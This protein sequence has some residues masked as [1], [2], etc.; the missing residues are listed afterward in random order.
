M[1]MK[2]IKS[3]VYTIIFFAGYAAILEIPIGSITIAIPCVLETTEIAWFEISLAT[4]LDII[5]TPPFAMIMFYFIYKSLISQP[6]PNEA[7]PSEIK[8]NT[9]KMLLYGACITFI[10]GVIMHAV[11]NGLNGIAGNIVPPPDELQIAIYYFDEVL[12]HKL[13][14][15]GIIAFLIG[16]MVIQFW[17]RTNLQLSKVDLFGVYFWP[18]A[19]G[20]GYMLTLVEG[21]AA[22]DVLVISLILIAVILYYI[23]FRG[24]KLE[25][26]IFTHF[27][28]VLL[29]AIVVSTIVF[30]LITGFK[31]G[32]PFF[33][34]L[35]ELS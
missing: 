13:I 10:V 8:K 32:Y 3:I 35:N 34:Q 11:A 7:K 28:L 21:Q 6:T 24:L 30:G 16:G 18:S 15:A 20:A 1:E 14:H 4:L 5:I 31:P 2:L 29:I 9:I 27:V 25:E 23:K 17:H 19:I 26:N 33:Y 12:G 22:F